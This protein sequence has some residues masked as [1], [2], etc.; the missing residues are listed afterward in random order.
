MKFA[1]RE[2]TDKN[3][4]ENFSL[5]SSPNSLLQSWNWGEFNKAL[6]RR[7]WRL[8]VFK[9]NNL[10]AIALV[11]KQPTRLGS[12]LYCPRGP[13]FDWQD[14]KILDPLIE[15]VKK[16]AS[17][18]GCIFIKIE[19]PIEESSENQEIFS[20]RSFKRASTFVQVEDAWLLPLDKPEEQILTE[21][22]KTT[23]YLVKHEPM[24]GIKIEVSNN[25]EDAK[26]FAD[27][28]LS[29]ARRKGFAEATHTRDYFLK[30]FAVLSA[31][32]QQR[33]FI[34]K[35]GKRVLSMAL[36]AFYGEMGY[37]LHA[38]SN[39]KQ[40]ESVGYSLQW[41]A[42][43]EAKRRGCKYY[44]FWGVVKDKYFKPTHPWYG[45][46]LFK[47]GFGGFRYTYLRAQDYPL[48]YKYYLYRSAEKARNLWRG[49]RYG[50]WVD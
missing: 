5:R 30:Q 45:F 13:I 22:R 48:N 40:K 1:V 7:I 19:P 32:D 42:I 29:T 3:V 18:E 21:M 4:W 43:K 33:V 38:A 41:E 25:A 11:I 44:N 8:G 46:S 17:K 47:K 23:R 12:Y 6:G 37:Y 50:Y 39:P 16:L 24:Q 20:T 35:K 36:V 10:V 28:L 14:P 26:A 49:L 9:D 31:D 34:A 27:L 15:T 2:I